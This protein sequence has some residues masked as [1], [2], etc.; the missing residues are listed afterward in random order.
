[1]NPTVIDMENYPRKAHF[2]YFRAMGNPYVGLTVEM[3]VTGAVNRAKAN[4]QSPF[5]YLLYAVGRAANG[6]PQFRQRIQ[7]DSIAEYSLCKTSHTVMK[8]D[9]TYTYC[10]A[11]PGLPLE[12]F[13]LEVAQKQVKAAQ[14]GVL[15]EESNPE[16]LIFVS[17]VPWVHYIGLVQP[18]PIPADSNPRITWGKYVA[19]EGQLVMPVSVLAHHALIDGRQLADFFQLLEGEL[20]ALTQ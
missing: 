18:T 9:G 2:D 5:L 10:E 16:G 20:T 13:L 19:K 15:A 6:V 3:D 11:D 17:C 1:M 14:K 8:A 7:G 4:G 12:A